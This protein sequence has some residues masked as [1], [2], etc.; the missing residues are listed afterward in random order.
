MLVLDIGAIEGYLL[1]KIKSAAPMVK[2]IFGQHDSQCLAAFF[3]GCIFRNQSIVLRSRRAL[4]KCFLFTHILDDLYSHD[5]II[6]HTRS[7]WNFR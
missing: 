1:C 4:R 2:A 3:D 5:G 7:G 6:S